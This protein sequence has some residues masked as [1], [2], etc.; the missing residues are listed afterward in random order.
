MVSL[1]TLQSR[2]LTTVTL[3][4]PV[5]PKTRPLAGEWW[6]FVEAGL[7]YLLESGAFGGVRMGCRGTSRT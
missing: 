4:R 2:C 1:T 5:R 7:P 6:R 3:T